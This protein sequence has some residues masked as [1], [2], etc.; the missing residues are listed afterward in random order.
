MWFKNLTLYALPS[1]TDGGEPLDLDGLSDRLQEQALKECGPQELATAGFVSPYPEGHDR[2]VHVGSGAAL[3]V[4]GTHTRVLPASVV[5]D[6][7]RVRIEQYRQKLGRVPGKR[8][9]EGLKDEVL[10]ELLPRA[11]VKTGRVSA[12]IDMMAGL[13]VVDTA[14][15][16]PGETLMGKLRDALGSFPAEPVAT[17][18]SISGMLTRWLLEGRAE[19]P[20][21]LGDDVELKDPLDTRAVLKAKH[22]DLGLDEIREHARSGKQVSRLALVY[23]K[24]VAFSLDEKCRL[25]GLKFLDLVQEQLGDVSGDDALAELDARFTLQVLELRRLFAALRQLLRFC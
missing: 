23:D 24:R 16:K 15:D 1:G 19:G 21:E 6:A 7:L 2:L 8:V 4:L 25:R 12:C 10:Q 14:S 3:L 17:E 20:F 18:E 22:H 13:V 5:R 11:F 9:R